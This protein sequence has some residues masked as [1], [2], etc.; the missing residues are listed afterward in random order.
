MSTSFSP[1][2]DTMQDIELKAL[3]SLKFT[4]PIYYRYVNDILLAVHR[5]NDWHS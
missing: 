5:Q 1:I 3:D 2:I 4:I